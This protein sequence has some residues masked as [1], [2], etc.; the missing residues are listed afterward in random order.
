MTKYTINSEGFINDVETHVKELATVYS[1]YL[2]QVFT[3][4]T[5]NELSDNDLAFIRLV[6]SSSIYSMRHGSE[7]NPGKTKLEILNTPANKPTV[8]AS[9]PVTMDSAVAFAKGL[10]AEDLQKLL[11][12]I[13]ADK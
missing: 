5:V 6:S 1:E 12:A 4:K 7:K 3:V 11:A 8:V 2:T 9:K 13:N 10:S